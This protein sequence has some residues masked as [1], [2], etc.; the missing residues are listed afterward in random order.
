MYVLE[1]RLRIL[2]L[3]GDSPTRLLF[4]QEAQTEAHP[5]ASVANQ[6]IQS[7]TCHMR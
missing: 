7:H 5:G 3:S 2:C 4:Q 1:Q 6:D